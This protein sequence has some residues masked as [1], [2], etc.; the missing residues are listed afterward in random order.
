MILLVSTWK[1]SNIKNIKYKIKIIQT[2]CHYI[3]GYANIVRLGSISRSQMMVFKYADD[4]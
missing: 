1:R 2:A 4:L 3:G